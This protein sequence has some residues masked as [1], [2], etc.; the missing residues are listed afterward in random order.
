MAEHGNVEHLSDSL[1]RVTID[2]RPFEV[3]VRTT[4]RSH[5]HF[6]EYTSLEQLVAALRVLRDEELARERIERELESE[7][8]P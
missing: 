7:K 4:Y 2:G 6:G 3:D 8:A 1:L 5:E